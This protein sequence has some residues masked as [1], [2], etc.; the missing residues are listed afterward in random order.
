MDLILT[1]KGFVLPDLFFVL[2]GVFQKA[3]KLRFAEKNT[4]LFPPFLIFSVAI[5]FISMDRCW[6]GTSALTVCIYL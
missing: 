5:D 6:I 3:S 4:S 1:C 2:G